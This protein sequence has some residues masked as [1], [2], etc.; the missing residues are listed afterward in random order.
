MRR[1]G[2]SPG[3]VAAGLV[4]G[5]LVAAGWFAS[6]YLGADDFNPTPV[7]SLTFIAPIAD[8]CNMSCCRRDRR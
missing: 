5:L 2:R 4:V 6:G 8:A 7:V 3:Q 1:S